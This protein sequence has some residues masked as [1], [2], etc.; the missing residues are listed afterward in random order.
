MAHGTLAGK[1]APT[2]TERLAYAEAPARREEAEYLLR[3]TA[4]HKKASP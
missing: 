3:K 1:H 4:A 2:A